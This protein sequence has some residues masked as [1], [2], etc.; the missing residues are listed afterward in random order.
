MPFA[1]IIIPVKNEE[2]YLSDCLDSILAQTFLDWEC[3]LIN[4]GSTDNTVTII[5]QYRQ[6]DP[7]FKLVQNTGPHGLIEALNIG[8]QAA[9]GLVIVRMDGDDIMPAQRLQHQVQALSQT[10]A[11]TVVTGTIEYCSTQPISDGYVAYQNWLNSLTHTQE[12]QINALKEC[13][14]AA[15]S[16][17]ARRSDLLNL[18]SHPFSPAIYPEDYHLILQMIIHNWTVINTHTPALQWRHYSNRTSLISD[19]YH[20]NRF[21]DLKAQHIPQ[22]LHTFYPNKRYWLLGTG[23][24]TKSLL[25]SFSKIHSMPS[26]FFAGLIGV[27]P[28]KIHKTMMG[29][30]IYNWKEPVFKNDF[31][32]IA[33]GNPQRQTQIS[34]LLWQQHGMKEGVHFVF[35]C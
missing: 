28:G 8:V 35:I 5:Q 11:P 7:R 18:N 1:S 23:N 31:V 4:D 32:L 25:K 15:P 30:T 19:N 33:A 27:H 16:W 10:T 13:P 6:K 9:I 24:S 2:K 21:W 3:I 17:A 20:Q 14:I 22:Y 34:A 12:Y 26:A 29:L